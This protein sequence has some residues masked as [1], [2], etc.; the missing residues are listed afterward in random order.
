VPADFHTTLRFWLD[1]GI[2]GFRIDVAD[3]LVKD[4]DL[5][6]LASLPA[7]RIRPYRD[8][9]GVHDIYRSWRAIA[10][11][12]PHKPIFVGELWDPDTTRFTRYLRPDELHTGFNFDYLSSPWSAG[13]LRHVI[14]NTLASHS[15]VG[16]VPTWVISNHDVTRP[17]TRFGREDS[18]YL[19]VRPIGVPVDL[20]IGT[21]RA[22]A[23]ALLG[24]AL[25]GCYYLYQGEELGLWEVEDLPVELRQD[26]TLVRSNGSDLGR[27]GCRVPLPWS[28]DA[29]PFGFG[30][31]GSTPWLPQPAQWAAYT[32]QAQTGD[33]GSMLELYRRALRIRSTEPTLLDGALSWL[34]SDDGVLSFRRGDGFACLVNLSPQP[35]AL[36]HYEYLLLAS[37][38]LVELRLPT[39]TAV[40][41]RTG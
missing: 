18:R 26:P 37:D 27:D 24:L 22:R 5:P 34:P 23:A 13:S 11:E 9:D 38:P 29:A 1:R 2:D 25:P 6:D 10:D 28:G 3:H 35:V 40:W 19:P 20:A 41:L 32:A 21:R 17:V 4:N 30:P 12:Y 36:P 15:T 33:R 16:A 39:D 8:Q 14:E 7:D 31:D